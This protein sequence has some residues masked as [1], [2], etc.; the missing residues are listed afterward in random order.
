[1]TKRKTTKV[2]A[3][4]RRTKRLTMGKKTL[5][6]LSPETSGPKGGGKISFSPTLCACGR[7]GTVA[8]AV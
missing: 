4:P 7:R 8:C 5:R 6:D 1:M 2:K 3:Q